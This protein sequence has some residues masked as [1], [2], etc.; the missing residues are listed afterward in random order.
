MKVKW[1]QQFPNVTFLP[2]A[3]PA[4]RA[5][6]LGF[7]WHRPAHCFP[8]FGCFSP[9]TVPVPIPIQVPSPG[10]RRFRSRLLG[11]VCWAAFDDDGISFGSCVRHRLMTAIHQNHSMD[12]TNSRKF[13]RSSQP[14]QQLWRGKRDSRRTEKEAERLPACPP[15]KAEFLGFCLPSSLCLTDFFW[16]PASGFCYDFI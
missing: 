8:P 11:P 4:I 14:V 15:R 12:M 16:F 6:L 1:I 7:P 5:A 3:R 9:S 2:K 10:S 13:S